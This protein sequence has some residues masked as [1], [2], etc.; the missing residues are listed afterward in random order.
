MKHFLFVEEISG[1][2]FIVGEDIFSTAAMAAEGIATA[3]GQE[4]NGGEWEL[5]FLCE[6]TDEEA[7]A[8][9]LDEY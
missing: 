5:Q 2:Q 4:Y 6:L 7:E 8:S 1:E 9:G 3:I